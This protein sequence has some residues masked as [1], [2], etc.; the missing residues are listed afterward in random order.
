[1]QFIIKKLLL[2]AS[3]VFIFLSL[4]KSPLY[5]Q[6]V[7][8][9]DL[10]VSP[11]FFEF[12]AKPG[13]TIKDRIRFRNNTDQAIPIKVELRKVSPGANNTD[14]TIEDV[15]TTEEFVSWITLEKKSLSAP[16]REWMDIPFEIKIP[17][18]AAFGYYFA[19]SLTHDNQATTPGAVISGSVAIPVLL[20][21]EKDGAKIEGKLLE[22]KSSSYISEFLPINFTTT[23][24][25]VGNVHIKPR[26]NIFIRGNGEKDIA[27]LE[28]NESQGAIL[29][30]AK[31]TFLSSWSDGFLVVEN[32]I[33]DNKVVVDENGKPKTKL[34]FNWN[35]L[36]DL[37]IGKYTASLLVVYDNG[38]RDI[39]IEAT[40]T[41]WV[42]P[43]KIIAIIVG[44]I[45]FFIFVLRGILKSYINR[46]LRKRSR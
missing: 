13:E 18:S 45:I 32:V 38:E 10:S 29:P 24:E 26:G 6:E 35:R 1:M 20:I 37:R 11:I 14:S 43:Y 2:V 40:T 27:I 25:N 7:D 16:P 36:T 12:R 34:A 4:G 30:G 39:P 33:K 22:F 3:L 15:T 21:V 44:G 9:L 19:F 5:A 23:V 42:I 28:V 17:E 41:F 8:R 31:R 46:E